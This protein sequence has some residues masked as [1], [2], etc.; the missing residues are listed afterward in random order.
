MAKTRSH[1]TRGKKNNNDTIGDSDASNGEGGVQAETS[2]PTPKK[3]QYGRGKRNAPAP[4]DADTVDGSESARIKNAGFAEM[5][6]D[7][8]RI[9]KR[10]TSTSIP[11]TAP[12]DPN[13]IPVH[14][15]TNALQM[16][17]SNG[18]SRVADNNATPTQPKRTFRPETAT[19]T[20]GSVQGPS[21]GASR[22]TIRLITQRGS[23]GKVCI[24]IFSIF[25]KLAYDLCVQDT[26]AG[27]STVT[28]D[29]DT[30]VR[31]SYS[32]T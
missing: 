23:S 6:E 27:R 13:T 31:Y 18:L 30:L 14:T 11:S 17:D 8:P 20:G 16:S 5:S 2:Q 12:E 24:S 7:T 1:A 19:V 9:D 29:S 3:C 21:A 26:P 4:A 15:D 22:P 28:S 10:T 32:C 25:D